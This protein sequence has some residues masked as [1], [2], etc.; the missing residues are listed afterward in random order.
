MLKYSVRII[1]KHLKI[2][3]EASSH[4][5]EMKLIVSGIKSGLRINHDLI[6][7]NLAKRRPNSSYNTSR[8]EQD[9]Y[10]FLTGVKDNIT[11]GEELTIVVK[12]NNINSSHYE[13]GVIR[14]GHADYVGY[15]TINDYD[16]RGGGC[17]SGRI[18]VLY[19]IL[20][21]ILQPY[22]NSV[23]TGKVKQVGPI[24]DSVSIIN[25]SVDEI[26]NIN[27]DLYFYDQNCYQQAIS[28]L[29]DC[30]SQGLS[31]G[32]KIELRIHH[33]KLGLGGKDLDNLEGQIAQAM[34]SIGGVKGINFGAYN[35]C[36]TLTSNYLQEQLYINDGNIYSDLNIAGG[37]NGGISNGYQD[38]Y[39]DLLI[40]PPSSIFNP[41]NTIIKTELGYQPYQ[42]QLR[43]RH[44][45]FIANRILPVAISMLYIVLYDQELD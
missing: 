41:I 28:Y 44:D 22:V 32:G 7:T 43:G 9:E 20:G 2:K 31:C 12:N 29:H 42:L 30:Q 36:D 1:M 24:N 10:Y 38:I 18:T 15:E 3:L 35:N 21:S 5:E 4:Q 45:T 14:P 19:V 13:Y 25:L 16:Y 17:F 26:N 34:F 27:N 33:P 6:T 23:V 37:I 8:I 11:T 40:K 39:F